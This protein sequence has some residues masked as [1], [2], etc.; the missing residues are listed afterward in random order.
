MSRDTLRRLADPTVVAL[1]IDGAAWP[2]ALL[3]GTVIPHG[4]MGLVQRRDGTRRL[5][6]ASEDPRPGDDD[7]VLLV[8]YR[9]ITV[10]L[11]AEDERA[12]CGNLVSGACELLVRWEAREDD[13]A[14]LSRAL[15]SEAELTLDDLAKA[16]ADAGGRTALRE[17][18]RATP[19][20]RLVRDDLRASLLEV[21]RKQLKRFLFDSGLVLERVAKLDLD[22]ESLAA[23]EALDRATARRVERIR[24]REKIEAASLA[25]T[26]RRLGD[27]TGVLEKLKAAADD[28]QTQWHELLPALSPGERG[29]LLENL[30]RITPDRHVAAAIAVVAG[31][32]CLW[33]DPADPEQLGRRIALGAEL[34]GLRSVGF[35]PPKRWL[36]VGAASGVW[37]IDADSG[38][39][40]ARFAV[41]DV[42]PPRTGFN[43]AVI[44][45]NRLYATHSQL[46]CWSWSLED[47]ADARPILEPSEGVP[48]RIRAVVAA[49]DGCLLFAADDCVHSYE[50]ESG[51][52]SVLGCGTDV[53]HCMA[54]LGGKLF[55]GTGDA[56]LFR[57]DIKHPDDWWLVQ[58]MPT[59][60]E[61]VR[62]RRWDDLIELVVP[63]GPRGVSGIFDTEG[64]VISLLESAT[65]IRRAWA[66]DDLVV[67]LNQLRD[68]LV[69]MNA[70]LPDR[71]G[72]E[73]RIARLTGQPIQDACIVLRGEGTESQRQ[74]DSSA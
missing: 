28:D 11:M 24:A 26:K 56:K 10:P 36:L 13:L 62:A 57:V 5:V 21:L 59:T 42:E 67:G 4:W 65:P 35:S 55:V 54:A 2:R 50:P 37:A 1:R 15:L 27:L 69:V 47:P 34:G 51:E 14:A 6:P 45:G 40:R 48:K 58:R 73:A 43:A 30:W 66:C 71:V 23:R 53:I 3:S 9:A 41:P 74:A 16:V 61:S 29:R 8:R 68:R 44:V 19:A 12:S 52:L 32:D 33:L 17:F 20:A 7:Q 46:G 39:T 22:S 64:V 49:D 63:A 60:I 18:I 31:N 38:E 72:R 70:N 25:A